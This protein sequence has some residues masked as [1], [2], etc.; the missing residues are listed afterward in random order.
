MKFTFYNLVG[1][2]LWQA[3]SLYSSLM[4]DLGDRISHIHPKMIGLYKGEYSI[5]LVNTDWIITK[6]N[7]IVANESMKDDEL[8]D[9]I[10]CIVNSYVKNAYCNSDELRIVLN[11]GCEIVAPIPEEPDDTLH[12]WEILCRNENLFMACDCKNIITLRDS[13]TPIFDIDTSEN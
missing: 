9:K 6:N 13:N 3:R 11:N 2:C 4:L 10:D 8:E 5:H 12:C 7:E 1:K